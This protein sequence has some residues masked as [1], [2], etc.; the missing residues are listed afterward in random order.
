[1]SKFQK[2][3]FLLLVWTMV[4][5]TQPVS[6]QFITLARKIKAKITDGKEVASVI[7]DAGAT[8][9]Y[10]AVT[11]TLTSDTRCKIQ[12]KDDGRKFVEFTHDDLSLTMQI[13]SL[14]AALSQITVKAEK[15]GD[16]S[17]KPTDAA[18]KAILA[19][20]HKMGLKCTTQDATPTNPK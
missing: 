15:S 12:N 2:I 20:C 10:H 16:S 3:F 1:M 5:H 11:D 13:D 8:K 18:V 6:A 9:V 19:V 4:F 7:L 17:Q 14:G